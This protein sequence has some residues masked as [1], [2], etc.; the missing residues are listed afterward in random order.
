MASTAHVPGWPVVPWLTD[1]PL[2][3]LSWL[4]NRIMT[5]VSAAHIWGVEVMARVGCIPTENWMSISRNGV[6]T[7]SNPPWKYLPG[8]SRKNNKI[9]VRSLVS[10]WGL[11]MAWAVYV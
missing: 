5:K 2:T 3:P 1:S 9:Q 11:F 10:F 8:N 7:V 6:D 4:V